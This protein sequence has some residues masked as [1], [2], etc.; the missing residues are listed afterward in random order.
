M[1]HIFNEKCT[2]VD[3]KNESRGFDYSL[4]MNPKRVALSVE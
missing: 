2:G 1:L 3:L 4:Y